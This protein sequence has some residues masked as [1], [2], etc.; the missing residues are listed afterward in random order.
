MARWICIFDDSPEMLA[1]RQQRRTAH[2]E[3]LRRNAPRIVR[4]GALCP[5]GEAP[6]GALWLIDVETRDAAVALVEQDPYFDAR[7][8]TYRLFEWKWALDYPLEDLARA[9]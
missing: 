6:T 8:R 3:F 9:G 5:P 7:Y 2:H 4:A 1:V